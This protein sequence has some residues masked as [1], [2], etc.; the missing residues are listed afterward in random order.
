MATFSNGE[1]GFSVR[2]K[3]N[4]VL[5][6]MDGTAGT[7]VVNEAGADVDFRVESDTVV[8]ALFVDGATGNV[9]LGTGTPS[10]NLHISDPTGAEL[11][12]VTNSGNSVLLAEALAGGVAVLDL[13]T[14]AG[15]NRIVGGNG[16]TSNI[17]F[18]TAS[19]ERMRITDIGNVGIG[20]SAPIN[21]GAGYT[22][23]QVSASTSG[24]IRI[25]NTAL[26]S[27]CDFFTDATST[28]I[29]PG[30]GNALVLASNGTSRMWID[31]S[32]NVGIGMTPNPWGVGRTLQ[33]GAPNGSFVF[34]QNLQAII[35][36]NAYFDT[37]W[38]YAGTGV[39]TRYEQTSVGSHTWF[40]APSG[41]AG[42]PISST[43]AMTLDASGNLGLGTVTPSARL[44]I[45]GAAGT[46]LVSTFTSAVNTGSY[47][48]FFDTTTVDRP[49]IGALGDNFVVRTSSVE[50]MRIT[51]AG[52]VG[53][54]VSVP[55][56]TVQINT[57]S[58][59]APTNNAGN[60]ALR[61]RSTATAAV[62]AGPSILFEGQTGNTAANY[63]F[64]G[65]QGLKESSGVNDYSG[66]LAFFTQNSGG[67][68]ALTEQMRINSAGNLGLGATPNTGGYGRAFEIVHS[69]F[70]GAL[71]AQA[72][73]A[74]NYPVSLTSN[75]VTSGP[76]T[77]KYM[78]T[79]SATR[80]D[81]VSGQH[82]W[83]IAPSGTAGG[84]ITFT[85]AMVLDA[86]GRLGIG[87]ASPTA[88]L[89]IGGVA[90]G[91]RTFQMGSS[92]ATRGVL[93]TSGSGTFAIG[94]T[95][96][97]TAG[98]LV[99][100][101]GGALTERMRINELGDVGIGTISPGAKL[102]VNGGGIFVTTSGTYSE[103]AT[104][105]GVIAFDSANGDLNISSRSNGGNSFTRFFTSNA[106]AGAERARID[107]TGNL[108]VGT[109]ATTGAASNTA[110]SV[111]GGFRTASGGVAT[112]SGAAATAFSITAGNRGRYDV[113]AMINN[114]GDAAL[115]TSFAT[116]L[117][118][119]STGR[120]VAN[121]ATSLTITLSG[122]NV[123]VTQTSGSAQTVNWSFARIAS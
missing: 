100:Q 53:I 103:P 96:D 70:G 25:S 9:G 14:A 58:G 75:A 42:N 119:G 37:T 36:S 93:S 23:L 94:A 44:T 6:H 112:T 49:L 95:N 59:T 117:W 38:R 51:A 120:I 79:A 76:N 11:A 48:G 109:T 2:T 80:Y 78:N 10:Y 99:F 46:N 35:G 65:I 86:S 45:V 118:D 68:S 50:R 111:S 101:T 85:Q 22:T 13:K 63:A 54:G 113:V 3:I 34:G 1:S 4:D 17:S 91:D 16:G 92:G 116:V 52:D 81:Q 20:T 33:L 72:I 84:A 123:Q 27:L 40:T 8:N 26:T 73:S 82:R 102:H 7:L 19:T 115:Y 71:T 41:T 87:V 29:R 56:S 31:V 28:V 61:L 64:A 24:A 114:S 83:I 121:N 66:T 55:A 122:S 30:T 74:D 97:S 107:N 90:G 69:N 39:S 43:Q 5:Q 47:V 18:Q 32:G 57:A 88:N 108:L 67:A 12:L 21:F 62:G 104:V 98:S 77:W 89:Q 106:G 60:G 105:A 15:L 110:L